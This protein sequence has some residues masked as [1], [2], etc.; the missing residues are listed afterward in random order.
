[1][2]LA[3]LGAGGCGAFRPTGTAS[4][5]ADPTVVKCHDHDVP[6]RVLEEPRPASELGPTGREALKG[7]E[8]R[9]I[10]DLPTWTIVEESDTRLAIIR[11]LD[12]PQSERRGFVFTHEFLAVERFGSPGPDGRPGWHMRSSGRCDLRK[13]LGDLGVA[14]VTLDPATPPTS[15]AREVRLLVTERACASGKRADDRVRLVGMETT[16]TEIRLIIGVAEASG[17]VRTCQGNPPTPFT[18]QLDE[19]LGERALVDAS[20]HPPRRVPAA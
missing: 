14:D 8:V 6:L 19:P 15:D 3:V 5:S 1:M 16:A 9:P 13:D 12:E 7:E 2:L 4:A 18:V 20:I 11:E 10:D 17:A